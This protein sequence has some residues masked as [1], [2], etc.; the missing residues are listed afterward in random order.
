LFYSE[1]QRRPSDY[2]PS[3]VAAAALSYLREQTFPRLV[4]PPRF[5]SRT[6]ELPSQTEALMRA[7]RAMIRTRVFAAAG[8]LAL[9]A[10]VATTIT[11]WAALQPGAASISAPA[12]VSSAGTTG[13]S[14]TRV[15]DLSAT[16]F[17]GGDPFVAQAN[18]LSAVQGATPE[19]FRFLKGAQEAPVIGYVQQVGTQLALPGINGALRTKDNVDQWVAAQEAQRQ[20]SLS[21]VA[22]ITVAPV[23]RG[24]LPGG[25]RIGGVYVTFYACVG[26]GFCGATAS[27]VQAQPGVAA[28]SYNLPFGTKFVIASDPS[29][30]VF[31][32]LDR[33]AIGPTWVDIWFYDVADGYAWQAAVGTHSDIIIVN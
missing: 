15:E 20:A 5:I 27:G 13:T 21:S 4:D 1:A 17:V 24:T 33:G 32:C 8:V 30:R 16:T 18:Y 9:I 29:Q 11:T 23:W 12:V 6:R 22:P 28:C 19:A 25:T 26:N 2:V 10:L 7:A 31:T 14:S 3:T